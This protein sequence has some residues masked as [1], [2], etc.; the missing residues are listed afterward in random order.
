MAGIPPIAVHAAGGAITPESPLYLDA[1]CDVVVHTAFLGWAPAPAV[2]G[3]PPRAGL[4]TYQFLYAFGARVRTAPPPAVVGGVAAASP[5]TLR[6]NAAAWSRVLTELVA[7]NVFAGGAIN[8]HTELQRL[9]EEATLPNPANLQITDADLAAGQPFTIPGGNGVVAANHRRLLQP[10]RFLHLAT[11]ALLE[12]PHA[13]CPWQAV[14]T[15][16]ACVGPC[17]TAP[18]RVDETSHMQEFAALFRA[19]RSELTT[20]GALARA[21]K[22]ITSEV[23]LPP[24]LRPDLLTPD[25][26]AEAA[27]DGLNYQSKDRRQGI[28]ERRVAL[29]VREVR[30]QPSPTL[31]ASSGHAS[32]SPLVT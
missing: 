5:F 10:V 1:D 21:L 3:G 6:L 31:M 23:R 27:I 22:N 20:D 19:R 30:F 2:G 13:R 28:E 32:V 9:V 14:T 25:A 24:E 11:V 7:A 26:L 8:D 15:L 17:L 4:S 18:S 29:L 12:D 16:A